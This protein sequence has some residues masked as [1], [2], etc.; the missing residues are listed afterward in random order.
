MRF[1]DF[2]SEERIRPALR[3]RERVGVVYELAELLALRGPVQQG[4]LGR[5]LL[6]RERIAGTV[7]AG[8]VAIPHCR[9]EGLPRI[10]ACVG[11]QHEGCFFGEP[12]EGRVRIFVGLVSPMNT[13]GLH[14]NLLARIAGMLREP[15]LREEL[16]A[17]P[18][19][20]GILQ[21]LVQAE[22]SHVARMARRGGLVLVEGAGSGHA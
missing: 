19:A 1:T 12:E 3:A 10:T 14:L 18:T 8:G 2:L 17:T 11:I 13:S 21:L 16:L 15:S 5:L 20:A 6:E 7:L 4:V 22:E 9:L